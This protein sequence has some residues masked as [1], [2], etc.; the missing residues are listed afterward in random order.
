[1]ETKMVQQGSRV[2]LITGCGKRDGIGAA[3]ARLLASQGV[4]V[5]I[6]DVIREGLS[7]LHSKDSDSESDWRGV[8]SLAAAINDAGGIAATTLGDVSDEA[9]AG[10]MVGHAIDIFGG[11]DI[12][13]NNAAAPQGADRNDIVDI[14]AEA[15]DQTIR[16]N[17]RGCF[18]MSRAAVPIMRKERW[19]RI[20][21]LSSQAA[22]KP[23]PKRCAYTASKAAIIG[24]T[25][26]LA[27]DLAPDGITVNA[28]LPGPIMTSRQLS[29]SR[30]QFGDDVTAGL[31]ERAKAIPA[32]R[33]GEPGEVASMIAYLT[34]EGAGFTT[35][36][37][38]AVSGGW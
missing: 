26:A 17:T 21:N 28:V 29:T 20:I 6:S 23:G 5:L 11:L 14:P 37:A 18:L 13:V 25:S 30:E 27:H 4:R 33:F 36:Q 10:R 24:F 2:A 31:A 3:T 12:L 1:M 35:G 34:S 38:I 7:N 19:G 22:V 15:W 16:I 32:G 9:D 8:A